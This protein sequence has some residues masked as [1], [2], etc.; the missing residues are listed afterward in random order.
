MILFPIISPNGD[1]AITLTK[2]KILGIEEGEYNINIACF[3]KIESFNYKIQDDIKFTFLDPTIPQA[4]YFR[5]I[6]SF[7][8]GLFIVLLVASLC[9]CCYLKSYGS[10]L[11]F[12]IV[13]NE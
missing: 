10:R 9:A 2:T 8:I 7:S 3:I 1:D 4:N 11:V 12:T 13:E 6:L 5:P